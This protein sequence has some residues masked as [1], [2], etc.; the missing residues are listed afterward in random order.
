MKTTTKRRIFA[1]LATTAIAVGAAGCGKSD[2]SSD[3]DRNISGGV[4]TQAGDNPA[5]YQAVIYR[6]DSRLER[7]PAEFW[8]NPNSW[9]FQCAAVIINSRWLVTL[10]GCVSFYGAE[11][12]PGIFHIGV[13]KLNPWAPTLSQNIDTLVYGVEE[14]ISGDAYQNFALVKTTRD[15]E[16]SDK[17]QPIALPFGM[18]ADWPAKGTSGQISG[19][20]SSNGNDTGSLSDTLRWANVDVL[21]DK[22][23]TSCGDWGDYWSEF[24][25]C[26]GKAKTKLGGLACPHDQ[27]GP[28]VVNV[29]DKPMLAGLIAE[30]DAKGNCAD[31]APTLAVRMQEMLK[32]IATGPPREL[33]ATPDDGSVTLSWG[34]P[35]ATWGPDITDY[36]I[37]MSEDGKTWQTLADGENTNTEVTF[38]D[39]VNGNEYSFRVASINAVIAENPA[40]RYYSDVV[41]VT[42]G[43]QEPPA[44]VADVN[45]QP[46]PAPAEVTSPQAPD[47]SQLAKNDV[48]MNPNA[49]STT[50]PSSVTTVAPQ[51]TQP[52]VSSA[53]AGVQLSTFSPVDVTAV[54]K[55]AK[56]TVPS[57]ALVTMTVYKSAKKVCAVQGSALIA[58]KTGKCKV[59][60]MVTSKGKKQSKS[61]TIT[62]AQ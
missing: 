29:A 60:V 12:K 41:K 40:M 62:V 22:S 1:L 28:F 58:L 5:P 19:W 48:Y 53:S 47:G 59:K 14:V 13:G 30:V 34:K 16:F 25:V 15:I 32:W 43:H 42:V 55:T 4:G 17:V 27:G 26:L 33:T 24:R 46:E 7:Y 6:L 36:A 20:G 2:S 31:G 39:L 51:T 23:E 54:T 8:Q 44:T 38:G 35:W 45:P 57:G 21:A 37:E 49:A 9:G 50:I 3:R 61:A 56:V 52:R 18:P 10:N 11:P